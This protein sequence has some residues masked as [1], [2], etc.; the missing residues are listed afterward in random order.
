MRDI[1]LSR[2]CLPSRNK[3][4]KTCED[5]GIICEPEI[6]FGAND[7]ERAMYLDPEFWMHNLD[8]PCSVL[9]IVKNGFEVDT[10]WLL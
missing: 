2:H 7:E 9:D 8:C 5:K 6:F 10:V 3:T 1:I 4:L